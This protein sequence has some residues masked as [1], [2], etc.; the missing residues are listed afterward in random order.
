MS[1]WVWLITC[2]YTN[3]SFVAFH[4]Y[5]II[6]FNQDIKTIRIKKIN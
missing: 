5:N 4:M 3:I 2:I 6:Y 1:E